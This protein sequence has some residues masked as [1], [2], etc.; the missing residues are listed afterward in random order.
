MS[1]L[2]SHVRVA[3]H[4]TTGMECLWRLRHTVHMGRTKELVCE[5]LNGVAGPVACD[6]F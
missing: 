2:L 1:N 3:G 4:W 6:S 5:V